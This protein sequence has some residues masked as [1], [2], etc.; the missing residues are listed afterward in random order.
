MIAI[1]N[2]YEAFTL[3][4]GDLI[5][6]YIPLAARVC[7]SL[8]FLYGGIKNLTGFSDTQQMIAQ[9]GLPLPSLMLLGNIVC[10]LIGAISLLLGY[11]IRWGAIVLILFLI[12][13]TLV[14]HD[15]WA[16]PKET[17]AFV[18]NVGLIGGLLMV[19]Y[20]GAGPISLDARTSASNGFKRS[21]EL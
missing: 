1:L 5:V 18:K 16:N 9:K 2:Y 14:F 10:Q 15:F 21:S 6:N 20:A 12:P 11:K 8:I 7:L 3:T 13:T 4:R 19:Y 17:I